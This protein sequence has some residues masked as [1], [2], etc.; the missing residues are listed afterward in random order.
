MRATPEGNFSDGFEDHAIPK[1]Q[2]T[3]GEVSGGPWREIDTGRSEA[4]DP[5]GMR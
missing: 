5:N 4:T 3:I 2:R 1:S